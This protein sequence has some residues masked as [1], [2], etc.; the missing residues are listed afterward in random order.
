MPQLRN[1]QSLYGRE[2]ELSRLREALSADAIGSCYLLSG[3]PGIG[4]TRLLSQICDEAKEADALVLSARCAEQAGAPPW[5][6][7][8]QILRALEST[9]ASSAN[10]PDLQPIWSPD[11]DPESDRAYRSPFVQF[12]AVHKLLETVAGQR[13]L[14]IAIDDMHWADEVSMQLVEHLVLAPER[15][16]VLFLITYRDSELSR[17]RPLGRTLNRIATDSAVERVKLTGLSIEGTSELMARI[18]ETHPPFELVRAI[19]EQT[20]GNPLLVT[21]ISRYLLESGYIAPHVTS[22]PTVVKIPESIRDVVTERIDRLGPI[23][24][25]VL[26]SAAVLG[27]TFEQKVLLAMRSDIETDALL[28]AL[29]DAVAAHVLSDTPGDSSQLEFAHALLREAIYDEL[30]RTRRMRLHG[31]AAE[32]I[33][34]C[35]S[36]TDP[37]LVA[38]A[39]HWLDSATPNAAE[40][41]AEYFS[42]AGQRACKALAYADAVGYFEQ[43]IE[44]LEVRQESTRAGVAEVLMQLGDA[45]RRAGQITAS[46]RAFERAADIADQLGDHEQFLQATLSFEYSR[47]RSGLAA[48]GSLARI[49]TALEQ[50]PEDNVAMRAKLMASSARARVFSVIDYADAAEFAEQGIALARQVDDDE[51]LCD[52]LRDSWVSFRSGPEFFQRRLEVCQEQLELA[53]KLGDDE[54]VSEALAELR[55]E[56]L[57]LADL[58]AFDQ[59]LVRY[60]RIARRLKEPH[61]LFQLQFVMAMRALLDGRYDDVPFHANRARTIGDGIEGADAAGVHAMQMFQ[62]CR[63]TGRLEMIKPVLDLAVKQQSDWIWLPGLALIRTE[64]GQLELAAELFDR[65]ASRDFAALPRDELWTTNL[66]FSAEVCARIG[67]ANRAAFLFDCLLPYQGRLVVLGPAVACLGPVD[68]YLGLLSRTL[69][70]TERAAELLHRAIDT[71]QR[72]ETLPWEARSRVEL[73]ELPDHCGAGEHAERALAIVKQIGIKGLAE[74]LSQLGGRRVGLGVEALTKRELQVLRLLAAGI[75]NK[76]ISSQLHISNATVATHVRNVL[77]KTG[78]KNRTEAAAIALRE[79][80]VND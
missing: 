18:S 50:V 8:M 38:L 16:P 77:G 2:L 61:H 26:E 44:C 60:E 14:V 48:P 58:S 73:A 30:N 54:R 49:H 70:D 24:R 67:D 34:S 19:H 80:V 31:K 51:L 69:G 39:N 72:I 23:C 7:W 15:L 62:L 74:R 3:D 76:Q 9:G 11:S 63:D 53:T 47:C 32:A 27:R 35:R 1:I 4:K 55:G 37:G 64:L 45:C 5:W 29:D 6:P 56:Q 22:L 28:G 65:M 46:M 52:T 20:G 57:E 25:D 41:A 21:E 79:G 66:A 13:S 43:A 59:T 68:R 78:A 75:S 10:Q 12:A 40:R 71:C 42:I 36:S 17:N 33:E